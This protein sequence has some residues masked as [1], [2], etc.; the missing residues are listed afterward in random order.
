ML[1]LKIEC[2][3]IGI[4]FLLYKIKFFVLIKSYLHVVLW[5]ENEKSNNRHRRIYVGAFYIDYVVGRDSDEDIVII[6]LCL[7]NF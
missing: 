5:A 7:G 2:L 4:F 1:K 6:K 3:S